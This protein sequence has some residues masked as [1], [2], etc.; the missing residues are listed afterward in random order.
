MD[1]HKCPH[2]GKELPT[3]PAWD[4]GMIAAKFTGIC[5]LVWIVMSH[6]ASNL[7]K[8]EYVSMTQIAMVLGM[9]FGG[10]AAKKMYD[11]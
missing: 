3:H 1:E 8:T 11:E 9:F 2:C 10:S 4:V 5:V 6:N 7:D